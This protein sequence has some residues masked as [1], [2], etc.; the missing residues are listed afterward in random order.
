M[1]SVGQGFDEINSGECIL[2][3]SYRIWQIYFIGKINEKGI[4]MKP[5]AFFHG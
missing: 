4:R 5:D 2:I 3:L 1:I